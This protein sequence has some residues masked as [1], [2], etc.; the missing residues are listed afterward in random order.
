MNRL[1]IVSILFVL[2]GFVNFS[3][4]AMELN[5]KH[6]AYEH[7]CEGCEMDFTIAKSRISHIIHVHYACP[8]CNDLKFLHKG[9]WK[10]IL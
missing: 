7:R 10:N 8:W 9:S 2:S 5:K 3:S 6:R 4:S 1:V